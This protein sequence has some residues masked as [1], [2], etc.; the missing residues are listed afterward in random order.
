[1][2]FAFIFLLSSL[3]YPFIIVQPPSRY[4]PTPPST[5]ISSSL[6]SLYYNTRIFFLFWFCLLVWFGSVWYG[7]HGSTGFVRFRVI[8]L[9]RFFF[10]TRDFL[11]HLILF[12]TI[13]YHNIIII[14]IQWAIYF[15]LSHL[16][17]RD[18]DLPDGQRVGHHV[19][20]WQPEILKILGG[21]DGLEVFQA[22]Q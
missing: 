17:Y 18:T 9:V 1:M 4:I 19:M 6:L 15:I 13:Y 20:R 22:S 8:T 3:T 21:G 14:T 12:L 2:V 16:R 5:V 7:L 10:V 11:V